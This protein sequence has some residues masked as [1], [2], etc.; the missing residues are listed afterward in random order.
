M[1]SSVSGCDTCVTGG[2]ASL[3]ASP[4]SGTGGDE[5]R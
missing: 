4:P 2:C 3:M 1:L 5:M